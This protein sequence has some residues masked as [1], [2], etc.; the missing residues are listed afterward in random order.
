VPVERRLVIDIGTN[1]TLALLAEID[2]KKLIVISD[3]KATTRLG[4]GL[5]SSGKLSVEAM[6]RTADTVAQFARN[7]NWDKAYILG[8]EALRIANNSAEFKEALKADSGLDLN[9]ISGHD[10]AILSFMGAMYN[11]QIHR[12]YVMLIDVGGGS[13]ELVVARNMEILDSVSVPIG[14]L[15]LLESIPQDAP[16]ISGYCAGRARDYLIGV[17]PELPIPKGCAIIAT[18]G[19]ITSAAA[20]EAGLEIYSASGI[21]G[22]QLSLG[23]L[24]EIARRF[25]NANPAGR[26]NLIPFDPDRAELILPGLGIF[27]AFM[28]II[29]RDSLIVSTGGLRF[30]AAL[31][32]EQIRS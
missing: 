9:I 12:D 10:E 1:S 15:K 26:R 14:A 27:L 32:P 17:L 11:L 30:G 7:S 28:S 3:L 31:Y 8:T 22:A 20:I 5:L 19:T 2:S 16:D 24:S 18:G 25:E 6:H 4:E 23:Q 21:H 29:E 13:T